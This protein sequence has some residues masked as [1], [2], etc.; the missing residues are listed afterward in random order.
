MVFLRDASSA[1]AIE[2]SLIATLISVSVIIAVTT[3][4][5]KL[6]TTFKSAGGGLGGS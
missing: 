3:V 6:Q 2:Y 5:S 4:C 1:T